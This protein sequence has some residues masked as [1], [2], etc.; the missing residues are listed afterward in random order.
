M[1]WINLTHLN[2]F[3]MILFGLG[4]FFWLLTYYIY[5]RNLIKTQFLEIPFIVVCMNIAWEFV[6]SM[7]FGDSVR[8]YMGFAMQIGYALW[9]FFDCYIFYGLYKYGYKQ[10]K[11]PYLIKH[12]KKLAFIYAIFFGFLFYFMNISG[13]DTPIGTISAYLDNIVISSAY[14]FIFLQSDNK[15]L[16]S[17]S[18]SWYKFIGTALI[19]IAL[20]LHWSH[21]FFLIYMTIAVFILDVY[22]LYI[23]H[24]ETKNI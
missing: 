6:W 14:I 11:L 5:I 9:F 21:N 2:L 8:N 23:F 20:D 24:K 17:K 12:S 22:Y 4:C 10:F 16:F 13:Y 7:V 1:I 19:S 3:E 18:V 15:H